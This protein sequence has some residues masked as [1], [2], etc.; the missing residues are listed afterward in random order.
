MVRKRTKNERLRDKIPDRETRFER[1]RLKLSKR[2]A[3]FRKRN[4]HMDNYMGNR[5]S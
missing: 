1:L 4:Q 3:R 5:Y 2:E